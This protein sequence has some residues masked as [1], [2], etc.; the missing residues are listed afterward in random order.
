MK[1]LK[2]LLRLIGVVQIVLGLLYLFMPLNFLALLGHSTPE[3]DIAYPLGMLAAR[4]LAYGVGMF[5]IARAP[6]KHGFW[7]NNMIFI[8]AVDLAVGIFYT[9]TGAVTLALSG[10]P[11]FNAALFIVL[12]WLWRPKEETAVS[13]KEAVGLVD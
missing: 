5:Y 11:M 1:P 10:F 8:Q 6:E 2:T 7:I 9:A 4:F 13:A 12:L 3:A